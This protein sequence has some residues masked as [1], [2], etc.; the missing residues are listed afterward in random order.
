MIIYMIINILLWKHLLKLCVAASLNQKHLLSNSLN[1][2]YNKSRKHLKGKKSKKTL[3]FQREENQ[4]E[5][6]QV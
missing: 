5:V 3:L 1:L 6:R 4:Q 2:I